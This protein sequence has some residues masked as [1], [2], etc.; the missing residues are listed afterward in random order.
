MQ[1]TPS[2]LRF[3]AVLATV[4][5]SRLSQGVW[6]DEAVAFKAAD[7]TT[8]STTINSVALAKQGQQ[9][10]LKINYQGAT[11]N[12][13][14]A[15]FRLYAPDR[16]V[17][18]VSGTV[19]NSAVLPIGVR[20][21]QPK[22]GL[23]RIVT[24]G[25]LNLKL[26]KATPDHLLYTALTPSKNKPQHL[27]LVNQLAFQAN[28]SE[29]QIKSIALNQQGKELLLEINYQ[30]RVL[31]GLAEPFMLKSP[32]RWVLDVP[33]IM[34]ADAILPDGVRL[35]QPKPGMVRIVTTGSMNFRLLAAAPN[36]LLYAAVADL[37]PSVRT[38]PGRPVQVA[39]TAGEPAPAVLSPEPVLQ[40]ETT[41]ALSAIAAAQP[42]ADSTELPSSE[43]TALELQAVAT[44]EL[45]PTPLVAQ[46]SVVV[47]PE[48]LTPDSPPS[49]PV[50]TPIAST[51]LVLPTTPEPSLGPTVDAV[52]A[53]TTPETIN[54]STKILPPVDT[55]PVQ[56]SAIPVSS[57]VLPLPPTETAVIPPQP[58]SKD[59]SLSPSTSAANLLPPAPPIPATNFYRPVTNTGTTSKQLIARRLDLE[60]PTFGD[61]LLLSEVSDLSLDSLTATNISEDNKDFEPSPLETVLLATQGLESG[62]LLQPGQ[63][64]QTQSFRA[65]NS[66]STSSIENL[67]NTFTL[68]VGRDVELTLGLQGNS[69]P[70]TTGAY[71][72]ERPTTGFLDGSFQQYTLQGKIKLADN[73]DFKSSLIVSAN[74]GQNNLTYL[75]PPQFRQGCGLAFDPLTGAIVC[76]PISTPLPPVPP[77]N[78]SYGTSIIPSLE[79]PM[80]WV[81]GT[82]S[83]LTLNPKLAFLSGGNGGFVAANPRAEGSFG[84]IGAIGLGGT[85]KLSERL[86]FSANITPILFGNNGIAPASGEPVSTTVYNAGLRYLVNPRLGVDLFAS[87]SYGGTGLGAIMARPD[88]LG[89][90]MG[91]SYVPDRL[92]TAELPANQRLDKS[93]D[94]SVAQEQQRRFTRGGLDLFDGGT[95]PEGESYTQIKGGSGGLTVAF[96]TGLLDDLEAGYFL[97]FSSS[98]VDE[99]EG[100][101]STK[102]R[103]VNQSQTDPVTMSGVFTIGRTSSR[104]LNFLNGDP[105]SVNTTVDP[106]GGAT[107]DRGPFEPNLFGLFAPR[108]GETL[109][110]SLSAPI[111]HQGKE[112]S[113][114]FTPK[115]AYIQ[116]A[117][118][119]TLAGITLGGSIKLSANL[120]L[121]GE[122]TPVLSAPNV[123]LNNLRDQAIP[124]NIGLRWS[125]DD[126]HSDLTTFRATSIDFYMTNALG[127]SPYQSMRVL[128]DNGVSFGVGLNF[129]MQLPF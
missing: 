43:P 90:G 6:A 116:Q 10:F 93:F 37:D 102:I 4:S 107:G 44:P 113:W 122:V 50:S 111:Q 117:P 120:E 29:P 53:T 30:G 33:G 16:W 94:L 51:E 103:F 100:G 27:P 98:N 49:L 25:M 45:A 39:E 83:S 126:L 55:N 105:N 121:L 2:S 70:G 128:A 61:A 89:L 72:V 77:I 31:T 97:N 52:A 40:T 41:L 14:A 78:Q 5:I 86:Q 71:Q 9:T 106:L 22:P 81:Q 38:V 101:L 24:D 13:L 84:P 47:L 112:F 87:N 109:I 11:P 74:V 95:L 67:A 91:V 119:S 73:P 85:F 35:G 110:L 26:L 60:P 79:L 56:S 62:A 96:R 76:I 92:L 32:D 64:I 58:L 118:N 124:W 125:L 15:P 99:S 36:R 54:D 115:L 65:Y 20:L 48:S 59:A 1:P 19:A 17:I 63:F 66:N 7:E 114:W 21:G 129:P 57:P 88:D 108:P 42:P 18:D 80:T 12:N 28:N 82:Q 34:A 46:E 123:L 104:F 75:T 68:G 127:L 23:V 8:P 69:T 3:V